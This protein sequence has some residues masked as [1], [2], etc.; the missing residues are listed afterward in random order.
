MD[1]T[2][3]VWRH[4]DVFQITKE[5]HSGVV[6]SKDKSIKIAHL[7]LT[8]KRLNLILASVPLNISFSIVRIVEF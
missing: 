2:G 1:E 6:S 7:N 8:V 4:F 3:C 5:C